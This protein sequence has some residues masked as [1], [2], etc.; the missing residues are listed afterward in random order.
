M[1]NPSCPLGDVEQSA[2]LPVVEIVPVAA[3]DELAVEAGE[4]GDRALTSAC[5]QDL[6]LV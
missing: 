4:A 2:E 5:S 6:V 1:P 3:A